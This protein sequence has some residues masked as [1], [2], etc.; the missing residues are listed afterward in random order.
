MGI[1]RAAVPNQSSQHA[2]DARPLSFSLTFGQKKA[3]LAATLGTV[4]E[5]T[6]AHLRHLLVSAHR[7][8]LP[9]Q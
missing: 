3:I 1:P 4:V 9:S 8:I 5:W 7:S 6:L 2:K